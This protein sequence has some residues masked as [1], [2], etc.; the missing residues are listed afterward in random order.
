[1]VYPEGVGVSSVV[2]SGVLYSRATPAAQSTCDVVTSIQAGQLPGGTRLS[3]NFTPESPPWVNL[4]LFSLRYAEQ[5]FN[6]PNGPA[7]IGATYTIPSGP[8]LLATNYVQG[9]NICA[10]CY[11]TTSLVQ[12]LSPGFI[13]TQGC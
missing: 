5:S 7:Y 13:Q 1:M 12:N 6:T 11:S 10:A 2:R 4:A 9:G 3:W 8:Q